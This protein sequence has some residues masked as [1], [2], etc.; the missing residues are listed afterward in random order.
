MNGNIKKIIALMAMAIV[1]SAVVIAGVHHHL[2]SPK[3]DH[4]CEICNFINVLNSAIL[5]KIVVLWILSVF[6]AIIAASKKAPSPE[7]IKTYSP[8]APPFILA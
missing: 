5:Q 8:R 7:S 1:F 6:A 3:A 2:P 4:D